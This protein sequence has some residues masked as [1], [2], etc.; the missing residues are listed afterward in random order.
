MSAPVA[1]FGLG[2]QGK[3]PNV[4][5]Q[6]RVNLYAEIQFE[7]DK[8][9]VAYYPTP[10]LDEFVDLGATPVRGMHT[11]AVSS[12]LY[13]VQY[14]TLYQVNAAAGVAS[15]G[16]LATSS[17]R[18]ALAD[19]GTRMLVVDGTAG[20]Y[21]N[22]STGVFS[23]IAD[24]DFPAGCTTCCFLGGRMV[25]EV[26]NSG[27]I[28]WSDLYATTWPTGNRAT[29]EAS[30]DKLVAVYAFQGNLLL[31]GE[32]TIE[33]WG[34][35]SNANQ[36]FAWIGSAA[37]TWGLAAKWSIAQ[38]ADTCAFLA[39]NAQGQVQVAR[40]SGYQVVPVSTPEVD[41]EINA[42][43][44]I[45]DATAYSNMVGGHPQYVINFPT[46]G[47][48]WMYDFASQ[49]WSQLR[50][51]SSG[52]HW[53]QMGVNYRNKTHVARFDAG[54]IYQIDPYT[55]TEGGLPVERQIIGRHVFQGDPMSVSEMW[56]DMEM[57]VGN[58]NPPGADPLLRLRTSKDGGHTWSNEL[59][60]AFGPQGVYQRRAVFR[61][62]GQ[63]RDW[64]F[65]LTCSEPVKTAFI[66]AFMEAA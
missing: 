17:G 19:D 54:K 53:G 27:A 60:R 16:T 50:S 52:M 4:T 1:L 42:Y 51:P 56:V 2:Q 32:T 31:M 9:R 15:L 44:A 3:S 49:S 66:G 14:D 25:V 20:Y 11:V 23:T 29:A 63:A 30:P 34:V 36:P 33:F 28:A 65:E 21:Y 7:A 22:V 62:L 43:S 64:V 6:T 45:E 46:A 39:R 35:T 13:A 24:A 59:W 41:Y 37:A 48:T 18:A 38:V 61:R 12:Y 8:T 58:A 40:L 26:P 57:G 55:Y 10:G 5:A 47:K